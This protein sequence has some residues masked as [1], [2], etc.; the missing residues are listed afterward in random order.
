MD[1]AVLTSA[2]SLF[3]HSGA[4]TEKS[5]DLAVRPLLA[6]KDGGTSRRAEAMDMDR[7]FYHKVDVPD[8]AHYI[9]AVF[10]LVIGAIGVTG[11]A[12]VIYAFFCNKKLRNPPNY[13]I[14][15]LAVSDFLMAFTQSP[16]FFIN[17][18]FKEWMFWET[19]CK[20]YAFCGALF[21]ITSMINLLAIS[22]DRYVVITKPLR[23]ISWSSRRRTSVVILLV[24]LYSLAWSLAPLLGWSSYVPEGLMTSCTWDYI[25]STPANK[26]YTLMLCCFVFFIPLGIISYCYLC[27]F[28]AIRRT[29]RD[30]ERLGTQVRKSTL[31]QQQSIKTEW[32]LAKIAFVVI[33]VYV[34]SWS[35][36]ACVTLI[37]WA[38]YSS[39]LTPYSKAVPAIIAK[40]STIYNP[41]IY[42]IIHTK[43]RNTLAEHVPCL[44]CLRSAPRKNHLSVSNSECSFRD[45]M[46]SRQSSGSN[47]KFH[48][49]SSILTADTVWS[50]V[51]LDPMV[52]QGR[53]LSTS[54]SLGVL[55]RSK[56]PRG[57]Q[58]RQGRQTRSSDTLEQAT[59]AER[60][61][62][63]TTVSRSD[64]S[65]LP[66]PTD[67]PVKMAATTPPHATPEH[68]NAHPN[69]NN[70][71]EE[72]EDSPGGGQR[73]RRQHVITSSSSSSSKR[74]SEME[75]STEPATRQAA[76]NV[77]LSPRS[78]RQDPGGRAP[79]EAAYGERRGTHGSPPQGELLLS[80]QSL[81]CS[82]DLLLQSVQSCS[83]SPE[84]SR[85][86]EECCM[87]L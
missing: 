64:H 10:V 61:P 59:V 22:L 79:E 63:A 84:A 87:G 17:S 38:G 66:Q 24:W 47:A 42:A 1:S 57:T 69:N 32:K 28:L 52:H 39:I 33:V 55:G 23:A 13:F 41:L 7:G 68:W 16:I 5:C 15:N 36:Y 40:A 12:L 83:F 72:R 19:G 45:S 37:A 82:S 76:A 35:P 70:N 85:K 62:Q 53:S 30:V 58:A 25:T 31:M 50:N 18:L 56:E 21:G 43:Y 34:L 73:R 67:P 78:E 46:L 26:S 11:N 71:N 8:H 80:L 54:C 74:P 20:M 9:V 51:G 65:P 48:R 6:L 60:R 49:V 44:H 29:S 27:M 81:K 2:G 75:T 4:K 14:I 77:R 3:H 86:L